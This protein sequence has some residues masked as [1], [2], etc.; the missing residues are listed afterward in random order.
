MIVETNEKFLNNACRLNR[1]KW[2]ISQKKNEKLYNAIDGRKN[3]NLLML[4]RKFKNNSNQRK[5]KKRI[6]MK[7]L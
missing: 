1:K 6:C 7:I 2:N 3:S 4:K 5:I